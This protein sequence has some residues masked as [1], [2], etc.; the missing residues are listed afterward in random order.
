M[1]SM[2]AAQ[3]AA[4][5]GKGKLVEVMQHYGDTLWQSLGRCAVPNDGFL[6][7]L[8]APEG[9]AAAAAGGDGDAAEAAAAAMQQLG[10]SPETAA[11]D[12]SQG[13]QPAAAA[14]AGGG[15]SS[16]EAGAAGGSSSSSPWPDD[17][18][19]LM[20]L[21]LLQVGA[22]GAAAGMLLHALH[23]FPAFVPSV[24]VQSSIKYGDQ[25][26]QQLQDFY[27]SSHMP[28]RSTTSAAE[29]V[30][31]IDQGNVRAYEPITQASDPAPT[32]ASITAAAAVAAA[33]LQA[34]VKSI[35]DDALP[36][37]SSALWTHHITPSRPPGD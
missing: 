34:I 31:A 32:L 23:V 14:A 29:I 36:L 10:L 8:V 15:S 7:G 18:D 13:R 26:A 9:A 1:H 6:Q 3:Q 30:T 33:G 37:N 19:Q 27:E 17:M 11:G 4:G 5:Q 25:A 2:A 35:K 16:S 24:L 21:A 28:S 20:E 22:A 12:S